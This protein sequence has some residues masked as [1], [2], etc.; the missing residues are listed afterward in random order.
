MTLLSRIISGYE[1]SDYEWIQD[2]YGDSERDVRGNPDLTPRF[3][4]L[5]AVLALCT[6][7]DAAA[8]AEIQLERQARAQGYA[9]FV[10][11]NDAPGRTLDE[12]LDTLR[13]ADANLV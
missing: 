3:C 7:Y 13:A 6:S 8:D 2:S 10:L 12:V 11:Y 4:P 1:S 9:S 5:G